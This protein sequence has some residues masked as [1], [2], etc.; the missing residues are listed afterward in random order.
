MYETWDYLNL[1]GIGIQII[2]F[3]LLLPRFID[4]FDK[5]IQ[6]IDSM[7]ID[8]FSSDFL[9]LR[10]NIIEKGIAPKDKSNINIRF[11]KFPPSINIDFNSMIGLRDALK[12]F[13]E[14]I[15]IFLVLLGLGFNFIAIIL[16]NGSID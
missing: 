15:G 16:E 1:V 3:V 2:G 14:G 12:K 5:K 10:F 11:K 8:F 13:R 4:W 7:T 9:G 6:K